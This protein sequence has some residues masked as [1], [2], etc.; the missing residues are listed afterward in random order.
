MWKVQD[1]WKYRRICDLETMVI[2]HP[3]WST[4]SKDDKPIWKYRTDEKRK[5]MS[6]PFC[7]IR[8]RPNC[9]V[10]YHETCFSGALG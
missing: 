6:Q 7:V 4:V 1:I 5:H 10:Q 8:S 2:F 3:V 9:W